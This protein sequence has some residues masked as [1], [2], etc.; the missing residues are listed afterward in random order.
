[1]KTDRNDFGKKS[2]CNICPPKRL[3]CT[4]A[5]VLLGTPSDVHWEC[6]S[7][8]PPKTIISPAIVRHLAK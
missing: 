2:M 8:Y 6:A 7:V 3:A 4:L 5:T 1:M